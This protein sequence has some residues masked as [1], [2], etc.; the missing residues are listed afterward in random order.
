MANRIKRASIFIEMTACTNSAAFKSG[1]SVGVYKDELGHWITMDASGKNWRNLPKDLRNESYYE[2]V[3]QYSM[4]LRRS[5][6]IAQKCRLS[7]SNGR[8]T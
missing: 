6:D 5:K 3:N 4:S 2:F 8:S 1:E 7:N